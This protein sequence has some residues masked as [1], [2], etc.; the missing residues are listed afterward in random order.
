MTCDKPQALSVYVCVCVCMAVCI[1]FV[2][3]DSM[4]CYA[5]K[6]FQPLPHLAIRY[7]KLPSVG[8]STYSSVFVF[9]KCYSNSNCT[10]QPRCVLQQR[11]LRRGANSRALF[12]CSTFDTQCAY[13]SIHNALSTNLCGVSVKQAAPKETI[14]ALGPW[15]SSLNV[16]AT[17]TCGGAFFMAV[18]EIRNCVFS[19]GCYCCFFFFF[20]LCFTL[21][22]FHLNHMRGG[23]V[24]S[25]SAKRHD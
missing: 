19:C 10:T 13:V 16:L 23:L 7:R 21:L 11:W 1:F 9:A 2:L 20:A 25:V 15:R 8:Y 17:T 6:H 3:L 4:V 14:S 5:H 12:E 24:H 22:L 18:L